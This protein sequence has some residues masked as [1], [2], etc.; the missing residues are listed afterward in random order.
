MKH[1]FLHSLFFFL[2]LITKV[3]NRFLATFHSTRKQAQIGTVGWMKR[4]TCPLRPRVIVTLLR[5]EPSDIWRETLWNSH[6][7]PDYWEVFTIRLDIRR[8]RNWSYTWWPETKTLAT[9]T[10]SAQC[11]L[12]KRGG[13]DSIQ[14]VEI[15]TDALRVIN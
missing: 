11:V 10:L 1:T 14:L 6:L 15:A 9:E 2:I 8:R 12:T 7:P 13:P 5:R 3:L 4:R